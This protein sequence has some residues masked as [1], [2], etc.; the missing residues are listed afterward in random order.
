ML[1]GVEKMK[2]YEIYV[3]EAIMFI[4]III[5]NIIYKSNLLLN[6]SITV[7]TI[8]LIGRYGVMKDNNYLKGTVIKITISSLLIFFMTTFLLG[9]LLG[10]QKS[11]FSL[12]LS[13]LI[14]VVLVNAL[15]IIMEELTRYIICRNTPHK[16]LPIIIYTFILVILDI[17]MEIKG[18][19]LNDR[20]TFFIFSTT[21]VVPILTRHIICSYLTYKVSYVPSLIYNLTISLYMYLLPIVPNLGNYLY[22]VANLGLPYAIYFFVSK[23]SNYKDKGNT[24]NKL[25]IRRLVYVPVIVCL[26]ILVILVS[27]LFSH[28]LIA[29][30]SNSMV[31]KYERGDAVIYSKTDVGDIKI[32]E[33]I[34]FKKE[35]KIITHRIINIKKEDKKILF[36]TKG[37]AN[38]TPDSFVVESNEVLGVV[39]LSIKYIGYP[40]IWL[41][42]TY[43]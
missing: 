3:I 1:N 42:D 34:A 40:T 11:V 21:I 37:D 41:N 20:E 12:N 24:Y 27:D 31:P 33:I 32:G 17:I 22:S 28:T 8:Y 6:L 25:V 7:I 29:I 13:Y 36:Y 19:N 26:L 9:L 14:K 23:L 4:S 10:F 18:Y 39:K 38:N 5:F 43:S 30:G 2:K 15:L 35:N 16:K